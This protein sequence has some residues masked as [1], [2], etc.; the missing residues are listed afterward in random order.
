[1]NLDNDLME[2]YIGGTDGKKNN[3]IIFLDDDKRN[4]ERDGEPSPP[5]HTYIASA[6][7]KC[8]KTA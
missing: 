2:Q 5:I 7:R 8:R 3:A 6:I 4:D 1:M